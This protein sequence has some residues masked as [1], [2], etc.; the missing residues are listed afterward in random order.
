MYS[1]ARSDD[2]PTPPSPPPVTPPPPPDNP[3]EI[4]T[5][6][7]ILAGLALMFVIVILFTGTMLLS[8]K[9]T[10]DDGSV[11]EHTVLTISSMVFPHCTFDCMPNPNLALSLSLSLSL[12]LCVSRHQR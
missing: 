7:W 2:T 5:Y 6:L 11:S 12:S 8:G 1:L 3:D 4:P 9:P 10:P